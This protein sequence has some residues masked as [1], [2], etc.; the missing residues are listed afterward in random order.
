MQSGA[1][2][3][4]VGRVVADGE[5]GVRIPVGIEQDQRG[6]KFGEGGRGATH[7]E[8]AAPEQFP[9]YHCGIS[10]RGRRV[11]I[12]A[13]QAWLGPA[14]QVIRPTTARRQARADI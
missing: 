3:R 10:N 12:V 2:V 7:I 1:R 8:V 4:R 14:Q 9:V 13:V 5:P 11:G 6:E